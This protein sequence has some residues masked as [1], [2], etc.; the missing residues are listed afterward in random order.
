LEKELVEDHFLSLFPEK[1][2]LIL[3]YFGNKMENLL[4]FSKIKKIRK[5]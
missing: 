3:S 2:L 1:D 5:K 4:L